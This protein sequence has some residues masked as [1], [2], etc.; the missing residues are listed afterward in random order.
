MH[1]E[2][3]HSLYWASIGYRLLAGYKLRWPIAADVEPAPRTP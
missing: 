1:T 2:Y 3:N